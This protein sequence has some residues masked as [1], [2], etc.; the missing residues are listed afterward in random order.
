MG[1]F[2]KQYEFNIGK[3]PFHE[4]EGAVP[5]LP[6]LHDGPVKLIAYFLPQFHTIPENDAWWGKGFTEWTNVT[7]ALPRYIGHRQPC[8]PADLGFYDLRCVDVLRKQAQL[9]RRGGLY[10]F[11]LHNYWF[12]GRRVLETPLETFL[13]NPEI[14]IHFCLNWA[15]ENWTRTWDGG[16]NEILLRQRYDLKDDIRYAESLLPAL[17]DPR[18]IRIDGRPLVMVYRPKIIPNAADWVKSWRKVLTENGVGDPYVVMTQTFGDADPRPYGMDAAAGF[19]PHNGGW[20]VPN[21]RES[22]RLL[23]LRFYGRALSY[24]A[25][26]R[27]TLSN[28]PGDY[29]LFPGIC[30]GWDNGARRPFVG[31]GFYGANPRAYGIWLKAAISQ[32][33]AAPMSERFVFINAWNEWAEG[34]YLEPDRHFGYAFLAETRRVLESI[35]SGVDVPRPSLP[36]R[37]VLKRLYPEPSTSSRA[38]NFLARTARKASRMTPLLAKVSNRRFD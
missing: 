12:S 13:K 22:M 9:A 24:E 14:D 5:P 18:Y 34:A 7:K 16:E 8:L 2:Y 20:Q 6:P 31:E 35:Q 36:S 38:F 19:P 15:N 25:L 28:N 26:A 1:P 32:A 11:C 29:R 3:G 27:R 4:D 33:M 10:G 30:P 23:D 21:D 37:V 17:R